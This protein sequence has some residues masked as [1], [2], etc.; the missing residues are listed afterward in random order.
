MKTK[1]F[2]VPVLGLFLGTSAF[3]ATSPLIAEIE[4][5]RRTLPRSDPAQANLA[6]KVAD[7]YFNEA[8]KVEREQNEVEVARTLRRRAV[9]LYQEVLTGNA[10]LYPAPGGT[11]KH[12]VQFQLARLFSDLGEPAQALPYW[13]QLAHQNDDSPDLKREA[14]LQLADLEEKKA[15]P[16][17]LTRA[18]AYFQVAIDLCSTPD[19]CSYA[20]YRHAWLQKN[21]GETE[22]ATNELQDAL[23]DSKGQVRE[24]VM[25]DLI[26]FAASDGSDG[27][28]ALKRMDALSKKASRPSLLL[29]L[30]EAFN[31]AGNKVAATRVLTEVNRRN[32]KLKYLVRELEER[33]GAREWDKFHDLLD[34]IQVASVSGKP[35][36]TARTA[37]TE[38]LFRRIALQLDGERVTRP[39]VS[40]D[41]QSMVSLYLHYFPNS[42]ER[43]KMIQGWLA[44]E[45]KPEAKLAQIQAWL[46]SNSIHLKTEEQRELHENRSAIAQELKQPLVVVAEMDALEPI[47]ANA[48]KKR[49]YQYIRARAYY[50]AKNY[51]E[52]LKGFTALANPQL[53]SNLAEDKEALQSQHLAMDIYNLRKDYAGLMQ[54]ASVWTSS[55]KVT[56]AIAKNP[57]LAKEVDEMKHASLQSDF[58]H[59]VALGQTT[60]ALAKFKQFCLGGQFT[61]KSCEN[62]KVLAVKLK[63]QGTLIALLKNAG[64]GS[65]S[66]LAAEYEAAGYFAEAAA[67]LQAKLT[68]S[69]GLGP[70]LKVALFYELASK[71]AERDRVLNQMLSANG[72]KP[73]GEME[74]LIYQTLKDAG[75]LSN[76]ALRYPWKK[77]TKVRL[78]NDLEL[79]G[80]GT[81]ETK[82]I[83]LSSENEVGPFWKKLVFAKLRVLDAE[84][85]KKNFYGKASKRRFEARMAAIKKLDTEANRWL[86]AAGTETRV[87]ILGMLVFAYQNLT[88]EVMNTP[89]PADLPAEAM[90]GIKQALGKM[91]EPFKTKSD[92]LSEAI[93]KQLAQ[94]TDT[95]R[96]ETLA[97]WLKTGTGEAPAAAASVAAQPDLAPMPFSASHEIAQA[98]ETLHTRPSEPTTLAQLEGQLKKDGHTRLAYYF[99][100]RADEAKGEPK[101]E[102][103]SGDRK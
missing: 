10:G 32:P 92:T 61:P 84:Q 44:A 23:M 64:S 65:E 94:V 97:A 63:E 73:F 31:A 56:Q 93:Q 39:E 98:I 12:K 14:S 43:A 24:E 86:N 91:A 102:S 95:S 7:L 19:T 51:D 68:P 58:E 55:S 50:E 41:F 46:Q 13:D 83:L 89:L 99:K 66:E 80:K 69:G 6:L 27:E 48:Q 38:N 77:E 81:T 22:K 67:L 30:S 78:A 34:Q 59:A 11:L 103:T 9:S 60:E 52:A 17:S 26:Q 21:R 1:K 5:L 79:A 75:F 33:Y 57:A 45:K 3:A 35:D 25:R 29:E 54:Q 72:S 4:G 37:E 47:A 2:S 82:E 53:S 96:K 90:E 40:K 28:A 8:S 36:E 49:G 101:A 87:E 100:G 18:E 85:K 70:Y 20:H 15:D 88:Q 74:P 76:S 42:T 62:A 71:K 16:A